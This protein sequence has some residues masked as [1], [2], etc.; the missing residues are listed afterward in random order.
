[1]FEFGI[2]PRMVRSDSMIERKDDKDIADILDQDWDE[3]D[4]EYDTV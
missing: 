3:N 2:S 1:M 4:N